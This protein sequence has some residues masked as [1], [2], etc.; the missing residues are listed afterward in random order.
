[1]VGLPKAEICPDV[2]LSPC[3][4]TTTSL[5]PGPLGIPPYDEV[6]RGLERSQELERLPAVGRPD[7]TVPF[8]LQEPD[9]AL[10]DIVVVEAN[11]LFRPCPLQALLVEQPP[12]GQILGHLGETEEL[13][14]TAVDRRQHHVGPEPGAVFADAPTF[15][16]QLAVPG[17]SLELP[18][19]DA[20]AGILG[21]AEEREVATDDLLSLG[22]P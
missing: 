6:R 12:L 2:Q 7:R 15:F 22:N 16:L 13:A 17:R 11:G 20:T 18:L 5:T 8:G 4:V 3:P 21:G 9:Q 19:A 1:M 10:A 14:V